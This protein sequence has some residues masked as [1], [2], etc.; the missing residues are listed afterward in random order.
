[1]LE[2]ERGCRLMFFFMLA[3]VINLQI[4]PALSN[5]YPWSYHHVPRLT[6]PISETG[7]AQFA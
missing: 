3:L 4:M 2:D 1:M 6:I 7:S 5:G